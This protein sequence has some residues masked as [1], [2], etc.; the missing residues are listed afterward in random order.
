MPDNNATSISGN[1]DGGERQ[2]FFMLISLW[3]GILCLSAVEKIEIEFLLITTFFSNTV[4]LVGLFA[5]A[6]TPN[7]TFLVVSPY[8]LG[9]F[10]G[11]IEKNMPGKLFFYHHPVPL[12]FTYVLCSRLHCNISLI[13]DLVWL[14]AQKHKPTMASA[15]SPRAANPKMVESPDSMAHASSSYACAEDGYLI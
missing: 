12:Y 7:G 3:W 9:T 15:N 4:C 8:C 2:S 13:E 6:K 14:R 1:D 10:D 5:P 11:I